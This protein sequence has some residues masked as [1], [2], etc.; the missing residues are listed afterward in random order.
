MNKNDEMIKCD[1]CKN[2]KENLLC[3]T[4]LK[5]YISMYNNI[6]E[7]KGKE[8]IIISEISNILNAHEKLSQKLN[9]KIIEEKQIETL[10]KL[11]TEE[12]EKKNQLE[13]ELND[14]NESI[15]SKKENIKKLNLILE[16][17]EDDKK[18]S[19]KNYSEE[20]SKIKNKI[21]DY[22]KNYTKKKFDELFIEKK[23]LINIFDFFDKKKEEEVSDLSFSIIVVEKDYGEIKYNLNLAI[24][25]LI[26]P[27]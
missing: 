20:L 23:A 6:I 26:I 2:E 19:I 27:F 16:S 18:I 11:I 8:G 15:K 7:T 17:L 9:K 12:E 13:K 10:D 22:K 24:L 4:C 14:L 3:N 21:L 5:E 25:D 1:L